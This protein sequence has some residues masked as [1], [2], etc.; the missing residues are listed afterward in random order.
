[1]GEGLGVRVNAIIIAFKLIKYHHLISQAKPG[2]YS[3][4]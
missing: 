1:M 2:K 3:M 4:F